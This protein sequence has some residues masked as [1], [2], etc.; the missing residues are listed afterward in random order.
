VSINSVAEALLVFLESLREPIIP[1]R[2]AVGNVK[3]IFARR[4]TLDKITRYIYLVA[5]SIA[6]VWN[7]AGTICS[8]SRL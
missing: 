4:Y 1:S 8:A 7:V 3:L 6:D 2:S 5:A